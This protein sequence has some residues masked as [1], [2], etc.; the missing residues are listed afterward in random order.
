MQRSEGLTGFPVAVNFEPTAVL[1]SG[2]ADALSL[3]RNTNSGQP[4]QGD[5]ERLESAAL[6]RVSDFAKRSWLPL[7]PALEIKACGVPVRTTA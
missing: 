1:A 4:A 6:A 3:P 7:T 5:F 2:G